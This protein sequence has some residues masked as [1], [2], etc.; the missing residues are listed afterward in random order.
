MDIQIYFLRVSLNTEEK[1]KA[2]LYFTIFTPFYYI[3]KDTFVVTVEN[4]KTRI[5]KLCTI[6]ENDAATA[7]CNILAL[8]AILRTPMLSTKI[9]PNFATKLIYDSADIC[10]PITTWIFQVYFHFLIGRT[11]RT[12]ILAASHFL[13]W[14]SYQWL[15]GFRAFN[16]TSFF[17]ERRYW[18]GQ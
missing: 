5:W 7:R 16:G 13:H 11:S 9:S 12:L 18:P 3:D 10:S 4:N 6:F 1:E 17:P 15:P 8:N 2:Y 14:L